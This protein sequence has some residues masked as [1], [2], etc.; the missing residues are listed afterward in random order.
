M[1]TG[2]SSGT[3]ELQYAMPFAKLQTLITTG[4]MKDYNE[5]AIEKL[6]H[7]GLRS[8]VKRVKRK[9]GYVIDDMEDGEQDDKYTGLKKMRLD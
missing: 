2:Q 5:M 7:S 4:E 9:V 6:S 8:P 1:F 3:G